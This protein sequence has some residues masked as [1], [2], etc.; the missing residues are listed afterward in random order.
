MATAIGFVSL[1]ALTL[2]VG[3]TVRW[4]T[5]RPMSVGLLKDAAVSRQWLIE[6]QD[7]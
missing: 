7:E 4:A 6:H 1:L 2:L 3:L 5:R